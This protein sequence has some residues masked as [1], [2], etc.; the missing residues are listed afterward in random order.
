MATR[1]EA[2]VSHGS[3]SNEVPGK[4]IGKIW[5]VDADEPLELELEGNAH[6]DLAG[7]QMTFENCEDEWDLEEAGVGKPPKINLG[8]ARRRR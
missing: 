1:L 8:A 2:Y 4:I 7:V 6:R 5:L 3:I